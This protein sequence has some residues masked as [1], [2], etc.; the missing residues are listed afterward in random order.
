MSLMSYSVSSPE[1]PSMR[2]V[3]IGKAVKTLQINKLDLN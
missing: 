3:T 2:I 1:Y